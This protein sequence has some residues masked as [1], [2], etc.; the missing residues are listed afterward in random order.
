MDRDKQKNVSMI[1]ISAVILLAT[2]LGVWL[3]A[4][5]GVITPVGNGMIWGC[6]VALNVASILWAVTLLGLQPIVVA[7]SYVVGGFLAFKGVE[8]MGGVSVAEVTTAGATYGAFGALAVGNY[9][10]KVRLAFYDKKQVPFIFIIAGLLVL[11]A[12][13][14]SGVSKAGGGVILNAVIIPFVLAGV[15]VGLIWAAI[16]HFGIG[17]KPQQA[18]SNAATQTKKAGVK[19]T[20]EAQHDGAL[21][22]EVPESVEQ[23][24]ELPAAV[25][26]EVVEPE[27]PENTGIKE[28]KAPAASAV[29]AAKAPAAVPETNEE[30]FFPLEIDKNDEF[31]L[32]A[33]EYD[34][35]D[36]KDEDAFSMAG[37]ES[38]LYGSN[39]RDDPQGSV[40][41]EEP[42]AAVS[43]DRDEASAPSVDTISPTPEEVKPEPPVEADEEQEEKGGDWLNGHMDLL[44]KLK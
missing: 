35:N 16:N 25:S 42:V 9:S 31:V 38:S 11:D 37:F 40:M 33:E 14:N 15:I 43:L 29:T 10:T 3:A 34:T 27:I 39:T 32:P 6:F 12:L 2:N 44:N 24:E 28:V 41:V 13:L 21:K 19:A 4:K 26:E 17:Y 7:L 23:K 36:Q 1:T 22:I 8:G 30:E 18:V 20:N 5:D